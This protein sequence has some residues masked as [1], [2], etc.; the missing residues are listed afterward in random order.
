MHVCG[1]GQQAE[2]NWC[3]LGKTHGLRK[4]G[5]TEF[6]LRKLLPETVAPQG[7]ERGQGPLQAR[8]AT[9][10]ASRWVRA[11]LGSQAPSLTRRRPSAP[12]GTVRD[13]AA[14]SR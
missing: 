14:T 4:A 5:K 7:M 13:T 3:G 9:H 11:A 2:R 1:E 12:G 10:A 6:S 8:E